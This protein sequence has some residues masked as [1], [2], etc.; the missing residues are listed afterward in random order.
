M[1]TN[2][3]DMEMLSNLKVNAKKSNKIDVAGLVRKDFEN[4]KYVLE[5]YFKYDGKPISRFHLPKLNREEYLV[6]AYRYDKALSKENS[7]FETASDYYKRKFAIQRAAYDMKLRPKD[8]DFSNYL[9]D[10]DY[11]VYDDLFASAEYVDNKFR[12]ENDEPLTIRDN[13]I[14]MDAHQSAVDI[15][16]FD[17]LYSF[18]IKAIRTRTVMLLSKVEKCVSLLKMCIDYTDGF[19]VNTSG[20]FLTTLRSY[21]DFFAE[22]LTDKTMTE[23]LKENNDINIFAN[24][25]L[26]HSDYIHTY[27]TILRNLTAVRS[28]DVDMKDFVR[29]IMHNDKDPYE[30]EIIEELYEDCST[31]ISFIEDLP[32]AE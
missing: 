13:Y 24:D 18:C 12:E 27:V 1:N 23:F 30:D 10:D 4:D 20:N 8:L 17:N 11:F 28:E 7:H 19:N 29:G 3:K 15:E 6:E 25:E 26:T 9:W 31:C 16:L 5:R 21:K 32:D 2:I 22:M 14:K